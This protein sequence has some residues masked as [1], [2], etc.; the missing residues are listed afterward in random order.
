MT[1]TIELKPST[2][3]RLTE[4]AK[5]EGKPIELYLEEFIEERVGKE[6]ARSANT[7]SSKPE[8]KE[9]WLDRFHRWLDSHKD[10]GGP[11]LSDEAVRRENMYEDRF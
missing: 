11:F 10:R 3:K 7:D 1:V 4:R 8:S 6:S 5:K 2:K 9:E